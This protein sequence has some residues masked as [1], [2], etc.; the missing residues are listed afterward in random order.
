MKKNALVYGPVNGPIFDEIKDGLNLQNY[1]RAETPGQYDVV[2]F[3][4]ASFTPDALS[5][6]ALL[7]NAF[8]AGKWLLALDISEDH[9]S[10]GLNKLIGCGNTG[11]S[12]AFMVRH[13]R[14]GPGHTRIFVADVG[15]TPPAGANK[16]EAS[17]PAVSVHPGEVSRQAETVMR[18][19][20]RDPMPQAAENIPDGLLYK[21]YYF[22]YNPTLYLDAPPYRS[23]TQTADMSLL[24]TY[25]IFLDNRNNPQ[26]NF[27]WVAATLDGQAQ[28]SNGEIAADD[29]R[30]KGWVQALFAL[31]YVVMAGAE[32]NWVSSSPKNPI[33]V[34]TYTTDSSF[35]VDFNTGGGGGSYTWGSST[36]YEIPDWGAVLQNA[37]AGSALWNFASQN[38]GNALLDNWSDDE[39]GWFQTGFGKGGLPQEP[40]QLTKGVVNFHVEQVWKT[41]TVET[42]NAYISVGV[43]QTL[44][45]F[46]CSH[47]SPGACWSNCGCYNT[48]TN[49]LLDT[50]M[51]DMGA[52]V[53]VPIETI[54]FEPN[55][56][57]AGASATGTITLQG[58][59][60]TD[61][62]IE[63]SSNS[64]NATVL[65][66]VTI[67][68]G[69]TS[70]QFE[71]LT[72]NNGISPGGHTV[73]TITA[74]YAQNYQAQLTINAPAR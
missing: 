46:Y 68:Q 60:P 50:H 20:Y 18:H 25:S 3:S 73:A 49:N 2:I 62:M 37:P 1:S 26:G 12:T 55:P 5:D 17:Q 59:A 33:P 63:I 27:Q 4:G 10:R 56:V 57:Q 24:F 42:Q 16:R 28:P 71:V 43:I 48:A 31:N 64:Q 14:G 53:P 52:V 72:N 6:D 15:W 13:D 45:C 41:N 51:L 40:N 19:L 54:R 44:A 32:L 29:E 66:T 9:K 47:Y 23:N 67:N 39:A 35:T 38:P 65:P 61:V 11:S 70:G 30:V 21:Q 69:A 58:P 36:T 34:Q 8:R 74:F 22:S 7:K